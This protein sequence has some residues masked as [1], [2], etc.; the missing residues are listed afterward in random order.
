MVFLLLVIIIIDCIILIKSI[1]INK[2][3]YNNSY[4]CMY[5][6]IVFIIIFIVYD[7]GYGLGGVILVCGEC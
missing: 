7:K 2:V 3:D 1:I 5:I 6:N 4:V